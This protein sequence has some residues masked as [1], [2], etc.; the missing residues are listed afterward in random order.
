MLWCNFP[1]RNFAKGWRCNNNASASWLTFYVG[2]SCEAPISLSDILLFCF[3]WSRQKAHANSTFIVQDMI[4]STMKLTP[5]SFRLSKLIRS[6]FSDNIGESHEAVLL[7][8]GLGRRERTS[9]G[10]QHRRNEGRMGRPA[11]KVRRGHEVASTGSG[12]RAK[13]KHMSND[14]LQHLASACS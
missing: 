3:E 12:G 7:T 9:R 4:Q 14:S 8:A 13:K 5:L 6:F 11:Y 1:S 2:Y 10:R